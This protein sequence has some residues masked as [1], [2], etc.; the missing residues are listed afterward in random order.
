MITQKCVY[1]LE[2]KKVSAFNTEHVI[3][4]AFG[5]FINNLTLNDCV[6]ADCNDFFGKKLE[7]FFARGSLE[8]FFRFHSGHKPTRSTPRLREE[9]IKFSIRAEGEW[10]GVKLEFVEEKG[11]LA[12]K[13]LPQVGLAKKGELGY[14]FLTQEE[15]EDPTKKIPD[16]V[17]PKAGVRIFSPDEDVEK[18]LIA[19]L[20]KRDIPFKK[21][22]DLPPPPSEAG[23]VLLE[24]AFLIDLV[25]QRCI[26]KIAFNYMTWIEGPSFA[27]HSD[28]N[29]VRAFIR[30]GNSTRSRVVRVSN[31][32][33]L[34]DDYP[35]QRQT[36]GHL[37]TLDWL[38]SRPLIISQI[39][40]YNTLTYQIV[41]APNFS[42]V[43]RPIGSGHHFDIRHRLVNCLTAIP[44]NIFV[45]GI[46]I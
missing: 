26:A 33:I 12:A 1:C 25:I 22:G 41:L 42:G 30:D 2:D 29:E 43:W 24:G 19:L 10:K 37:I 28:F 4:E 31:T 8:G 3:P 35:T 45:P 34:A 21:I 38:P 11:E 14:A 17:D 20:D 23:K 39:S 13:M 32:P 46:S 5:K 27:L 44:R 40:L 9:R 36:E 18:Q 16:N 15:L 6:C 7:L